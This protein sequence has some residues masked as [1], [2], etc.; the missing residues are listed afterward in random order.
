[1]M[2]CN[3]LVG[4]GKTK[5]IAAPVFS[6]RLVRFVEA[7][8][9]KAYLLRRN[10]DPGIAYCHGNLTRLGLADRDEDLPGA[11]RELDGIAEQIHPYLIELI[12]VGRYPDSSI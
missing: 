7:L 11:R 4:D 2:K 8:K 10:A 5:A 9:N 12:L 6:P 3:N 1:M